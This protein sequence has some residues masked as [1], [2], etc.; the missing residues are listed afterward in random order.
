MKTTRK[1]N[2][3]S[4]AEFLRAYRPAAFPRP[5]VTVDVAAFSIIDAELRVLL[6][7]RGEHPFKGTWALPGGFL[8]VGD[9]HKDQGEDLDAAA[10]RELHEETALGIGD[11]YLEQ[12]GA[13]GRAGRDPRMRVITVAYYALIR[14]DLVP[15]AKA[16]GDAA[17]T[18][19]IAVAS[20][21]PARLAFD[22]YEITQRAVARIAE[23]VDSSSIAA[24]L[25]PKTFTIPELRHVHS[26]LTGRPHDPGNFRRKFERL[27]E[28]G[29]VERAPGKRITAS[30]PATVYRFVDRGTAGDDAARSSSIARSRA[31]RVSDAARSNSTRASATRPS[32]ARRSPRTLGKRW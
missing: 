27:L 11:V 2:A 31:L 7:R 6:V 18:D 30:K 20:L 21:R 17:A 23:R 16:G 3:R 1:A 8:R 28:D 24:S 32:F 4:E 19:W 5:S 12:L 10:A 29:V 9:A 25:V 15:L 22:H 14:P 13:F 26:V